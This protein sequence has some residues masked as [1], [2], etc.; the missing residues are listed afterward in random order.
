MDAPP[1]V[2][3]LNYREGVVRNPSP[4]FGSNT[5]EEEGFERGLSYF[6]KSLI[7]GSIR[8]Y[9]IVLVQCPFCVSPSY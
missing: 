3:I 4:M 8:L 1:Y 7:K 2:M 5:A 6:A 9:I